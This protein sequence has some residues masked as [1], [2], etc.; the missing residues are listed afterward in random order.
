MVESSPSR[1]C[2]GRAVMP[3]FQ[4]L[5]LKFVVVI[6]EFY[7]SLCLLVGQG[8]IEAVS[9]GLDVR[10]KLLDDRIDH[11][12]LPRSKLLSSSLGKNDNFLIYECDKIVKMEVSTNDMKK[13]PVL[14]FTQ[15]LMQG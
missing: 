6:E 11:T 3:L 5:I 8:L 2:S 4:G 10:I 12:I 15:V 13:I 7:P 1:F 14:Y 9:G